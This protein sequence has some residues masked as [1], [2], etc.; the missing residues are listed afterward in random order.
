MIGIALFR[1]PLRVLARSK[2]MRWALGGSGKRPAAA[3]RAALDMNQQFPG[4]RATFYSGEGPAIAASAFAITA[5]ARPIA[6]LNSSLCHSSTE[7]PSSN[8]R[9]LVSR[10]RETSSRSAATASASS[11]ASASFRENDVIS[12]SLS[13]RDY[14]PSGSVVTTD[15]YSHCALPSLRRLVGEWLSSDVA[16]DRGGQ[17]KSRKVRPVGWV[18]NS[19]KFRLVRNIARVSRNL[20]FSATHYRRSTFDTLRSER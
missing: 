7:R 2:L 20:R 3:H 15:V 9:S 10:A 17:D 1:K 13:H 19:A 4:S 5:S 18:R 16:S 6:A 14:G 12:L 11:S 8:D